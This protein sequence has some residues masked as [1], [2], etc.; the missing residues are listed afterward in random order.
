M[1]IN[2]PEYT[3]LAIWVGGKNSNARGKPTFMK[4]VASGLPN[5]PPRW[6]EVSA[7]VKKILYTY[8]EDARSWERLSD[9]V[10]RIGWPQFFEKCDLPFT[11]YLI[12]DWRG[13]RASLNASAHIRF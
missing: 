12:D 3:K 5:N 13:S 7:M 10:E 1:Q 8:K 2:D 4:M 6:P 9:W 11:K